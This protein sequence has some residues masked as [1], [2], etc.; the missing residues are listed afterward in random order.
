M[1]RNTQVPTAAKKRT[2][3][4]AF[5]NAEVKSSAASSNVTPI[6]RAKKQAA[7]TASADAEVPTAAC[8]FAARSPTFN[9]GGP[10]EKK[11]VELLRMSAEAGVSAHMS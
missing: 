9:Q 8:T 11:G 7:R 3:T 6:T 10:L 4:S 1:F 2:S 5:R